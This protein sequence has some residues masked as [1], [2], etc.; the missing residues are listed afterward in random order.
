MRH[1]ACI[2]NLSY[3][4][5]SYCPGPIGMSKKWPPPHLRK[6][7]G[8]EASDVG[9]AI[10]RLTSTQRRIASNLSWPLTSFVSFS[11]RILASWKSSRRPS[12]MASLCRAFTPLTMCLSACKCQRLTDPSSSALYSSGTEGA[13]GPGEWLL[14]DLKKAWRNS[15]KDHSGFEK[16]VRAP[17]T[18][19][20]L[21]NQDFLPSSCQSAS[22]L[23]LSIVTAVARDADAP[24]KRLYASSERQVPSTRL[25]LKFNWCNSLRCWVG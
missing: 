21:K 2:V 1:H 6:P 24:W 17:A 25:W 14:S 13:S 3:C 9:M 5:Q 23:L 10:R 20:S 16:I 11:T 19:L 18:P 7:E 12:G 22:I 8:L 4:I 15:W